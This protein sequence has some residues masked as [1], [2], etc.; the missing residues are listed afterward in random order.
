MILYPNPS[1]TG[2]FSLKNP[3]INSLKVFDIS[4]R[5]VKTIKV[6]T[7][8]LSIDLG[9]L[10]KGMFLIQMQYKDLTIEVKKVMIK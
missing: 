7:D 8:N 10:G 9:G 3:E 1:Y 4:G 2:V 5:L 6:M